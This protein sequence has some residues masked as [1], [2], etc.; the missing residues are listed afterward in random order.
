ME[1]VLGLSGPLGAQASEASV[2]A[3]VQESIESDLPA[4]TNGIKTETVSKRQAPLALQFHNKRWWKAPHLVQD[5]RYLFTE[6]SRPC[7]LTQSPLPAV[8]ECQKQ[9]F[10]WRNGNQEVFK[11][12]C[13]GKILYFQIQFG[14]SG[15]KF[16][17]FSGRQECLKYHSVRDNSM[18]ST[19]CP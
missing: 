18:L 4:E 2:E 6:V 10:K 17:K 1:K 13:G 8:P 16:L 19:L 7:F 12:G 3:S 15:W 11:I 14:D 5:W 9:E